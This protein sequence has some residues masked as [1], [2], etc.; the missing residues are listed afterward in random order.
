[1]GGWHPD[2]H[3]GNVRVMLRHG[4]EQRVAVG[5]GGADLVATVAEQP[6]EALPHHGGVLGDHHPHGRD[7]FMRAVAAWRS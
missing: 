3:H 2:V 1:V 4:G 5:D 6:D 7:P